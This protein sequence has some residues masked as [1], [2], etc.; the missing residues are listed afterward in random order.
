MKKVFLYALAFFVF[1]LLWA[2]PQARAADVVGVIES[3]K[4]VFQ[5]PKF[6]S[7]T[8]SLLDFRRTSESAAFRAVELESDDEKKAGIYE[9]AA[10]ELAEREQFLMSPIR[11]DCERAV[12]AVMKSKKITVILEKDSVYLG[13]TDITDD[14][15]AWLK[16]NAAK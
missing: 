12:Q 10:R 2:A 4:I 13:G 16:K 1:S 14:V 9:T 15:V 8:K 7:V 11:K 6:D 5:H 3:Q